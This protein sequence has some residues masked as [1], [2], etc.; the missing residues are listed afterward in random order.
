VDNYGFVPG[1]VEATIRRTS[2]IRCILHN[3]EYRL[4]SLKIDPIL[5]GEYKDIYASEGPSSTLAGHCPVLPPCSEKSFNHQ[6][7]DFKA[8]RVVSLGE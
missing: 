1:V 6:T 3:L 8:V 4:W 2:T 5:R 7:A